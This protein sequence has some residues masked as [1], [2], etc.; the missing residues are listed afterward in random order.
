MATSIVTSAS[1]SHAVVAKLRSAPAFH[2]SSTFAPP[3]RDAMC[4]PREATTR[5][6]IRHQP[7]RRK[8]T[9]SPSWA[10]S[11][12]SPSPPPHPLTNQRLP[13]PQMRIASSSPKTHQ[14]PVS[15]KRQALFCFDVP[16]GLEAKLTTSCQRTRRC[17]THLTKSS[18]DPHQG[19]TG[20]AADFNKTRGDMAAK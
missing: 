11:T 9:R 14:E 19:K 12:A 18:K 20:A 8:V 5:V 7:R 13:L 1:C 4:R 15:K 17:S 2:L 16:Q 6:S 10:S 3:I